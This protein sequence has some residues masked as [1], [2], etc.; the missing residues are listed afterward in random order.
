[1]TMT[2]QPHNHPLD[3]TQ[4]E[5]AE[6]MLGMNDDDRTSLRILVACDLLLAKAGIPEE[7]VTAAYRARLMEEIRN[8]ATT[9]LGVVGDR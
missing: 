6:D 2:T 7:Q 4:T 5:R 3:D 1:M 9:M 8:A